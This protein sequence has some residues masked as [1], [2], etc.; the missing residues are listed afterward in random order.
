MIL[1][2]SMCCVLSGPFATAESQAYVYTHNVLVVIAGPYTLE[3][4]IHKVAVELSSIIE[5]NF[6]RCFYFKYV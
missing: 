6:V 4:R 1:W 2:L 3:S 5:F